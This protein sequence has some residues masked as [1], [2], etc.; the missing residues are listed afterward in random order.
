MTE[1]PDAT[2]QTLKENGVRLVACTLV[3]NA[4]VTRVKCVPIDRLASAAQYGIGLSNVFA[5]FA[6]DDHITASPGYDTPSGDMRL[7]PDLAAL[8]ELSGA[9]GWAWAPVDQ[10]DQ[11]LKVMPICQRSLLK[12]TAETAAE[13]GITFK[14]AFEL[15]FTLLTQND[16][17][18][19][20]GPGYSP[21]ALLPL[22]SFAVDVVTAL[23]AQGLKVAQ[24]HP[25][26]SRGQI[27]M[28]L[29]ALPPVAAADQHV[30]ARTTI[31]RIAARHGCKTSFA[32]L[33][34]PGAV[35]NG[36]HLHFSAWQDGQNLMT[37]GAGP[38]GLTPAGAALTA[39]VLTH[40]RD[41]AAVYAPSVLS[42]G[43]LQPDKWSGGFTCWG[44]ENREAA[45]RLIKGTVGN[46]DQAANIE[47]KTIDHTANPYLAIAMLLGSALDGLDRGLK[48]PPPLQI[49]P[50]SLSEDQQQAN[51]VYR[52]PPHL[53]AAIDRLAQ[54]DLA[55]QVMG[56]AQFEAFLATRR[57]EW[58]SYNQMDQA[59]L[60]EALR[61]RYG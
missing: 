37:N 43:R 6:V 26:Y 14:M 33:V 7:I 4:G 15:E 9:P 54:S 31:R 24:F 29:G 59:Q 13:Q 28:S 27:E 53:G 35:G 17:P 47:L 2:I 42:Y 48:P 41:L 57:L 30:L 12:H 32:P 61:W 20:E 49:N 51:Q 52:L 11:D 19:H 34:L 23:E 55:R 5:V 16:E 10:Y 22:E 36:C 21:I 40:L 58:D 44:H 25:E 1:N 45:L 38:E 8:V 50:S 56:E 60:T 3:D 46:R 39:G 18:V